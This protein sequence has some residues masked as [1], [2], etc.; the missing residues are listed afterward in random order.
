VGFFVKE[1]MNT[2]QILNKI[3]E[4]YEGSVDYPELGSDDYELRLALCNQRIEQ[5]QDENTNWRELYANSQDAEDGDL[6]TASEIILYDCPSNF[7]RI[8]SFIKIND[9]VYEYIDQDEVLEE[10]TYP[11]G[12]RYFYLTGG[13]GSYVINLSHDPEGEYP[14]LYMY[15]K[16]ATQLVDAEDIPEM[17]R[18]AFIIHGVLADLYEQDNRNDMVEYYNNK[19]DEVMEQMVI[20]NEMSPQGQNFE[21]EGYGFGT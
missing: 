16:E 3:H 10:Q 15:Y 19:A 18:T 5:W 1:N 2:N 9:V 7:L 12:K 4:K 6:V 8:S 13:Y 21:V 14:I 17:S 20:Q 11:T